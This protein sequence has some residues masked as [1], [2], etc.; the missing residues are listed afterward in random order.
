[1]LL[2][3]GRDEAATDQLLGTLSR[4]PRA[5]ELSRADQA[6]VSFAITLTRRPAAIT[7][8]DVKNLR[9][10]GLDDRAIHDICAVTAYYNFVNRLADGLG[11]ELETDDPR[12]PV[13]GILGP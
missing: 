6:M 8:T 10:V 13:P 3:K 12:F 9:E 4:N 5:A 2:S 1:M 11:V 7:E